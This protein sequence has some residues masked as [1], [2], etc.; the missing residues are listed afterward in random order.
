MNEPNLIV[1]CDDGDEFSQ[2]FLCAEQK[3]TYETS[4]K[5]LDGIV[6]LMAMYYVFDVMYNPSCKATL[7]FFQDILMECPDSQPR[8]IRY[9][10]FIDS[11]NI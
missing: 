7:L 10:T 5:L 8:P 4:E 11:L 9:S 3:V 1:F 2:L 6:L